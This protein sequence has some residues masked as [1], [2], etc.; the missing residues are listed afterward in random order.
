MEK[1][2]RALKIYWTE[3]GTPILFWTIVIAVIIFIVQILNFFAIQKEKQKINISNSTGMNT[4][5]TKTEKNKD[6]EIIHKFVE[7]CEQS[8]IEQAYDMLSEQ[9]KKE[10]YPTMNEFKNGYIYKIFDT[11]KEIEIKYQQDE[12]FQ[13]IFYEDILESGKIENRESIIDYYKIQQE[14]IDKKIYIN[15]NKDIK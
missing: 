1:L 11:K 3:H 2:R 14:V 9:C 6:K 8:N 10:Q 13:V 12:I 7:L 5:I 15:I 4:N